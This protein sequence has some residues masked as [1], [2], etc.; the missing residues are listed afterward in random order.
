MSKRRCTEDEDLRV[1]DPMTDLIIQFGTNTHLR[2]MWEETAKN[3]GVLPYSYKF[4]E[5][6]LG[7]ASRAR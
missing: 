3:F 5:C 4:V 7:L 6:I 2:D 1:W